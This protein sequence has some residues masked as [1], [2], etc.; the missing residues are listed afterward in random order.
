MNMSNPWLEYEVVPEVSLKDAIDL[1]KRLDEAREL[2]IATKDDGVLMRIT[3]WPFEIEDNKVTIRTEP[4]VYPKDS[5]MNSDL[6]SDVNFDEPYLSVEDQI[7]YPIDRIDNPES[8]LFQE[9]KRKGLD[10]GLGQISMTAAGYADYVF[11]GKLLEPHE[12]ALKE[13]Q[14]EMDKYKNLKPKF[15]QEDGEGAILTETPTRTIGM[16][17]HTMRGDRTNPLLTYIMVIE[18]EE[19]KNKY[20][21]VDT[22]EE[23]NNLPQETQSHEIERGGWVRAGHVQKFIHDVKN[24]ERM[25]STFDQ[26][27]ENLVV[28][29]FNNI[30]R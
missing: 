23:F 5:L 22:L 17:L 3:N 25:Y 9:R 6:F 27:V 18:N 14:E 15:L 19:E 12:I 16:T 7:I 2:G 13:F 20:G 10:G 29:Y 11:E 28:P 1:E 21:T 26:F 30:N 24:V 8:Y 4:T